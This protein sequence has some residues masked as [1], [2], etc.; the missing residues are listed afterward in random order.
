MTLKAQLPP[1]LWVTKG[2]AQLALV[3]CGGPFDAATGHYFDNVIVWAG[4]LS[5]PQGR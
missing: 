3:T 5:W 2:P 1:Q 4:E